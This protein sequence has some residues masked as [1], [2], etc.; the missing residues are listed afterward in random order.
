MKRNFLIF[1][2]T[3][4]LIGNQNTLFAQWFS[5]VKAK[6]AMVVTADSLASKTGVA[7][8][9]KGGNAVDAAVAVAFT[10][11]VT[12]PNAGNIGGGGF[13]LIRTPDNKVFAL[14][15]RE[16]APLK[17]DRN[18]YLDENGNVI[19][20]ASLIGYKACGVP[21]TV[22]GLWEAH[23]RFGKLKWKELLQP[24]IRFAEQGFKI[25][26]LQ[27]VMFKHHAKELMQFPE[28]ARIFYPDGHPLREG[29]RLIQ[30]DLAATLKRIQKYGMKEFYQG[31]TARR[32]AEDMQ[33]HGGLISLKDLKKYRAVWRQ[34]IKIDY[35]NYT[36]F[37]MP[38][39]SSGGIL[40]AEILN[41]LSFFEPTELG[42]NSAKY[43]QLLTEIERQAYRDR[44]Q[45][46]GDPD[47][48]NA[49]VKRLTSKVY[50]DSIRCHLSLL[51]AGSSRADSIAQIKEGNQTTHFSV[52]DENGWAVSNTYTLNSSYGSGVVI[53]GTGIL[54][55]NEMD[56]FSIKPG[57]PNQFGL[58]GN[59]ANA[60]APEKRMLSSM[61]PTI[62]L[63]GDSLFMVVGSPG[64]STIITSVL[65]T[66]LNAV[67]FQMNIRRAIEAPRFH[68]Q[69][70]PDE[71]KM[72]QFG[73]NMDTINNL[74]NLGYRV[75][76]V[77]RLGFVQGI[78]LKRQMIYGWGDP[79]GTG[80]ALGF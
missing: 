34:P 10:L 68:H 30:K 28:T 33:R 19:P 79:R 25:N 37:S 12:Y 36:V 39:P 29:E 4:F 47:F 67:D 80:T 58:V 45:Y 70:L 20:E 63:K 74:K 18:M 7:I 50:A 43:I 2:V 62:V 72:E 76:F 44:A 73:F 6:H 23:K 53:K 55:N 14:D 3:L 27:A 22:Y 64:G 56:D 21:G 42:H 8:L 49:P 26:A 41:T 16:K 77:H 57:Q 75:K 60:I 65:Q 17:A 61:S 32:I 13:M 54:M 35:R 48:V 24:A 5:P 46:L 15:Y 66:I 1:L 51:K 71:I 59:E 78:M 40:L 69:W 38:L 11:A 31:Q 52:C 9:K